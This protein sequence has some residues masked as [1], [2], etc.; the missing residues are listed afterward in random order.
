MGFF[1]L[2]MCT[3]W[4]VSV[5]CVQE[6]SQEDAQQF[7]FGVLDVLH[8]E[9]KIGNQFVYFYFIYFFCFNCL[10]KWCANATIILVI[11]IK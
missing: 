9:T 6:G 10:Y 7:L 2:I 11:K 4:N 8:E 3:E 5:I 1:S